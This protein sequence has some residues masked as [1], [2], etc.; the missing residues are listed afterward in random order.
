MDILIS[1]SIAYDYLMRFPVKFVDS[2]MAQKLDKV[3]LSFLVDDMTRHFGGVAANIAYTL[4]LLGHRPRLMG[5]A[6]Q[7][8]PPYGAH[9]EAVGVDTSTVIVINEVFCGSFFCNTDQ[10]NNQI[11]SFY[12]GAMSFAGN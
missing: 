10:E 7:D 1:G 5:T 11:A 12:A 4:A 6:G 2:L 3:S 8:F 9:L